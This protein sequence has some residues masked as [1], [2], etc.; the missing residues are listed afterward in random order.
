MVVKQGWV[1]KENSQ[2]PKWQCLRRQRMPYYDSFPG[3]IYIIAIDSH[4]K[5][6]G[7]T[8]CRL[9][10]S[11][12]CKGCGW[13]PFLSLMANAQNLEPESPKWNLNWGFLHFADHLGVYSCYVTSPAAQPSKNLTKIRYKASIPLL[14]TANRPNPSEQQEESV[15]LMPPS[16]PAMQE[17]SV[18]AQANSR[19]AGINP[20]ST[21]PSIV[22]AP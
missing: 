6:S 5:W 10:L 19:S 8:W 9:L 4:G 20:H 3:G 1:A 21:L 2:D 22:F 16:G 13:I 12:L 15:C 18:K 14:S 17:L 7:E 11:S